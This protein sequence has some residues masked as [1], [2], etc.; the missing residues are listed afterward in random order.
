MIA[1][2]STPGLRD[3][4][5]MNDAMAE[6][7]ALHE[8]LAKPGEVMRVERSGCLFGGG[9]S[10]YAAR[11]GGTPTR[12]GNDGKQSFPDNGF[13]NRIWEP[14]CRLHQPEAGGEISQVI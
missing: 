1:Q 5:V 14:D 6:W 12:S 9:T 11:R 4:S 13:P 3:E 7:G 2:A 8:E 10:G